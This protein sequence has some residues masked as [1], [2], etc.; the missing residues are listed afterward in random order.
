MF[1]LFGN[2][3]KKEN[4]EIILPSGLRY[5]EDWIEVDYHNDLIS[6]I[7]S[8]PWDST[9]KRR[10]QQYGYMY[11][12]KKPSSNIYIGELPDFLYIIACRLK[13]ESIYKNIPEQVIINEY[14]PGQGIANHIDCIP[15]FDETIVSLSLG[16]KCVMD[17]IGNKIIHQVLDTRSILILQGESRYKYTHGIRANFSDIIDGKKVARERRIS[18]T[19]RNIK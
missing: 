13:E 10:V 6:V 7:D 14:L 19:F 3:I 12:Y 16:S 15:C 11:N 17:I 4:K 9:L 8:L 2:E 18:I 1:D 5:I